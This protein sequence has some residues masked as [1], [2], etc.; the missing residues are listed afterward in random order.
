MTSNLKG[1]YF[2]ETVKEAVGILARE[3]RKASI[4][5]GGTR[6]VRTLPADLEYLVDIRRLPM[7][8]IRMQT[9]WLCIGSA[10][11]FSD[12][13]KSNRLAHWA[14]GIISA[15]AS[16][17]SSRPIRNMGTVGGNL[18]RPYPYNLL[19]PVFLCLDAQ[20]VVADGKED[21]MV[22][23]SDLVK[24][25]LLQD[26]GRSVLLTE[27]RI[28][29][30]TRAWSGVFEKFAK[31]DSAWESYLHAAVALE[32]S[33]KNCRN[34]RIALGAL[35]RHAERFCEAEKILEGAEFRSELAQ[36]AA[37]AAASG[38]GRILGI[39]SSKDYRRELAGVMVKRCL[40]KAWEK[41]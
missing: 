24:G 8:H 14:G 6:I 2:P 17:V 19:P 9:H 39:H 16:K 27:V 26:L 23:L 18:V 7:R 31:T 29:S 34:V 15:A 37:E 40:L 22:P 1:F 32:R 12:L 25:S 21:R 33:G 5:A 10:S 3:K 38:L 36:E 35:T 41:R 13:E 20:A 4:L 30:A 28:P 11:T